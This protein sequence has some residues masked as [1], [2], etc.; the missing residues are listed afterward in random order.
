MRTNSFSLL[1]M[2]SFNQTLVLSA[3]DTVSDV[4]DGSEGSLMWTVKFQDHAD[5]V[6]PA[7]A[8][9]TSGRGSQSHRRCIAATVKVTDVIIPV[10]SPAPRV[11]TL[12]DGIYELHLQLPNSATPQIAVQP[13]CVSGDDDEIA[14]QERFYNT[15]SAFIN[16]DRDGPTYAR[17]IGTVPRT[18]YIPTC[19]HES[20]FIATLKR[21]FDD[22]CASLTV[23]DFNILRNMVIILRIEEV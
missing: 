12:Q 5:P 20:A 17:V 11:F 14:E 6:V 10:T 4:A 16:V 1:T 2:A 22:G 23:D 18:I 13:P 8:A 19:A 7:A 3:R 9:T 21:R 15:I